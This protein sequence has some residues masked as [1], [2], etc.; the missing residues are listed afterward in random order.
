MRKR[1]SKSDVDV[2]AKIGI[3]P[4][5]DNHTEALFVGIEELL[6]AIAAIR[7]G[8]FGSPSHI[9]QACC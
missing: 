8:G 6:E 3:I 9:G 7:G 2:E 5:L 1:E 4:I